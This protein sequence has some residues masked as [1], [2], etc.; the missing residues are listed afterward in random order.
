MNSRLRQLSCLL[1]RPAPGP[2]PL[3]APGTAPG[4]RLTDEPVLL[5]H[6]SPR[7]CPAVEVVSDISDIKR[8]HCP[9]YTVPA[10]FHNGIEALTNRAGGRQ[11]RMNYTPPLREMQFV[12]HDVLDASSVL[13]AAGFDIDRD[14]IDGVLEGAGDICARVIAPLNASG[15]RQGCRHD[16]AAVVT[17]DGFKEAYEL[18]VAGGW[19]AV[20][21]DERPA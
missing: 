15:D 12:L 2:V 9:T 13:D 3:R 14:T 16:G 21:G 7:Q 19:P 8:R 6:R 11:H 1:P 17:P 4:G 18:Y 10:G 20:G 5:P